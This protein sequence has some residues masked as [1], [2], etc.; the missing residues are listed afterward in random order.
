MPHSEG[1]LG[2]IVVLLVGV[3]A[4]GKSWTSEQLGD[5]F[6]YV[7]H[8]LFINMTGNAYLSA[9]IERSKTATKPLLCEAPFSVSQTKDP[10]EQRGFHVV[11]V[12]L[13]EEESVLRPRWAQ[14]GNVSDSTMRGHLSRQLTYRLRAREAG[15]FVGNSAQ[16]LEHLKN[17]DVSTALR[18]RSASGA[19]VTKRSVN[20]A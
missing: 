7:H 4:A 15:D 18:K 5:K 20:R 13:F 10:L 6:D 14:R 9:I 1:Q 19:R 3:P 17:F 2:K 8:D 16:V 12:Y 11:P